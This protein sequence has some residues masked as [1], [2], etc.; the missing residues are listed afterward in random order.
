[1]WGA[2]RVGVRLSPFGK[3]LDMG[4]SDPVALFNY[5]LQQ[6]SKRG[7]AYAHIIETRSGEQ[8]TGNEPRTSELFRP[9]FQ[10]VLISAG[11]YSAETAEQTIA[12]TPF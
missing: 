11:G 4:D 7:I 5:V 9:A 8:A 6:L 3:F 1:V 12:E 10:G 2:D